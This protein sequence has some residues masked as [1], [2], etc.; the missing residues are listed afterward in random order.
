MN[1]AMGGLA[2]DAARRIAL[3]THDRSLL[4]EAGAGSGKTAVMAGRIALLVAAGVA[5][6]AIA[7]VTFTELAASELVTRVH[8]FVAALL[9]D[10]IPPELG[11]ALPAGLSEAQRANLRV[12]AAQVDEITCSTIHGFCQRLITPYP[13]EANIDPG[14]AV[15]DAGQAELI[16]KELTERWLRDELDGD[17]GGLLAELILQDTGGTLRLTETVLRAMRS[18]RDLRVRQPS[19]LAVA[20]SRF[21]E[22]TAQF[23]DLLGTSGLEEAESRHRSTLFAQLAEQVR[24]LAPAGEASGLA[25]LLRLLPHTDLCNANGS[26][27]QFKLKGKWTAAA[28]LAGLSAVEGE[29]AF[30]RASERFEDCCKS[31]LDLKATTALTVLERLVELL[32][33]VLVRFQDHKRSTAQLDFDDLIYAARELLRQ[34]EPVRVALSNRYRHVLVDEFQDTDPLQAEIFWRLC[35]EVPEADERWQDIRI[36]PGALFLVGDP[37]QAIYRFRGAD[38]Q[39]YVEAREAFLGLDAESVVSISTN[40]RSA[41]PIL[42]FVNA[43][44]AV[45]LSVENLQPGFTALDVFHRVPDGTVAVAALD[46]SVPNV[47]GRATAQDHRDAEAEAVADLCAGLIGHRQII[48]RKTGKLRPCRPGDIA[49][50]APTGT[51]LWR[52]EEPLERRGIPVATQAG[53]GLFW[54]QEIQDLVALTRV[55]A[56]ARDSLA[57][58][59]LLRGPLVGL[60][61]EQLLDVAAALPRPAG[62]EAKIPVLRVNVELAHVSHPLARDV[63]E[64]LQTLRRSANATTPHNLLSQAVDMLRVRPILLQRHRGQ[65]ERALANVDLYLSLARPYVIRG[66][67]AFSDAMTENWND[68][69]KAVE[70]RPDSQEE[71]VVVHTM[72]AAKGLEWPVVIPINTATGTMGPE[73]AIV[74]RATGELQCRV[75][76]VEPNGYQLA[77]DNEM[78]E[79]MRERIRVWYVASTR[80]RELLVIPRPDIDPAKSSWK[81]LV[82]LGLESLPAVEVRNVGPFAPLP[83][84]DLNQQSREVF[85]AEAA[86]VAAAAPKIVWRAPSR[87]DLA[88]P[89]VGVEELVGVGPV[90]AIDLAIGTRGGRSRGTVLH[91]LME[92]VLTGETT[93]ERTALVSRAGEL[94]GMFDERAAVSGTLDAE[95]LGDCIVR[96][97]AIPE[98]RDLRGRLAPEFPVYG[99]TVQD[100]VDIVT[101]GI[102][103]AVAFDA[104]GRAEIVIDWKSD[105]SPSPQTLAHYRQQVGAYLEL[106]GAKLGLIVLMSSAAVLKVA[107]ETAL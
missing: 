75:L 8:E 62:Q 89:P 27:K 26:F 37:K 63:L 32:R 39:A 9:A 73:P 52:Y 24:E 28:K 72:H 13:V 65:A 81:A 106:T 41:E 3:S 76:G 30:N 1:A 88:D 64:K 105:I 16:F 66:L 49:L 58:G 95:E 104:Q 56:D 98:I 44:F 14:A 15:M 11:A 70:G 40:F 80:A 53:K 91:K 59:A 21:T 31:W 102:A 69:L 47:D 79:Q 77:R 20:I 7:A 86:T 96:S 84:A 29:L 48:D 5:P 93:D 25:T 100:E 35:G 46:V 99:S 101:A 92:E 43:C 50:L 78:A 4:V 45:P 74:D 34:H 6:R 54:R 55:L 87:E 94:I 107:R 23:V 85:A 71:S 18:R 10:E 38:V 83:P 57:L 19:D 61:D 82:D 12:A 67:K 36:R 103:D 68:E 22:A 33:P 90:D 17:A 42:S 97:L 51:D 60:S 2:D